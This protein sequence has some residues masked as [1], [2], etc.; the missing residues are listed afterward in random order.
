MITMEAVIV[1]LVII[2]VLVL[3]GK[4]SESKSRI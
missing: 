2:N 1:G 3:A 4:V